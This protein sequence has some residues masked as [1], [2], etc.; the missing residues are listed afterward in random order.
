MTRRCFACGVG[1]VTGDDVRRCDSCAFD[2]CNDHAATVGGVTK[3]EECKE[4]DVSEK[5]PESMT[6]EA[7]REWLVTVALPPGYEYATAPDPMRE[8]VKATARAVLALVE[9][10]VREAVVDTAVECGTPKHQRRSADAI[11]ARV[12][13]KEATS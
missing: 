8:S 1:T 4:A 3:C 9:A 10:K 5:M 12:M 6:E 7:V 11:V 2:Y 13:G